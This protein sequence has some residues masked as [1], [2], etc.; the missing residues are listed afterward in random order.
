VTGHACVRILLF[1]AAISALLALT[2]APALAQEPSGPSELWSEFPLDPGE[3]AGLEP[4]VADLEPAAESEPPAAGGQ[5]PA[6]QRDREQQSPVE[7]AS[8]STGPR[9]SPAATSP[10]GDDPGTLMWTLVACA[11]AG[12][13]LLGAALRNL[14]RRRLASTRGT[15][16]V[17]RSKGT[18][19]P[20]LREPRLRR[21][22][23]QSQRRPTVADR[24]R[25]PANDLPRVRPGPA[26][27]EA[28]PPLTTNPARD[29]KANGDEQARPAARPPRARPPAEPRLQRCVVELSSG[30][31]RK[32]F[33]ARAVSPDGRDYLAAS[34]RAFVSPRSYPTRRNGYAA[35]AHRGLLRLLSE[36]GW[37]PVEDTV[38]WYRADRLGARER[39]WEARFERAWPRG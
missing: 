10:G 13:V 29:S 30:R 38:L 37:Q 25:R 39:W 12:L 19:V 26:R 17:A 3:P 31:L 24:N 11:V 33:S 20:G 16:T 22:P 28:Q 23:P 4:P 14:P 8:T 1:A 5:S 9:S 36:L 18:A 27:A 6:P 21:D 7:P 35:A 34:S 2:A 15:S 32:Q